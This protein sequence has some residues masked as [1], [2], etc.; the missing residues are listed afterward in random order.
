M[1][2]TYSQLGAV[3]K[4]VAASLRCPLTLCHSPTCLTGEAQAAGESSNDVELD[5]AALDFPPGDLLP[6]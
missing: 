1:A 6:S 5:D 3:T 4:T 2:L